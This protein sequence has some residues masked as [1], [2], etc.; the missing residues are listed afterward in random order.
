MALQPLVV[1]IEVIPEPHKISGWVRDWADVLK[2]HHKKPESRDANQFLI[3]TLSEKLGISLSRITIIKGAEN[4]FKE[5]KIGKDIT[6]EELC[7]ILEAKR[8]QE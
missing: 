2:V 4:R 7:V 8:P 6:L 1:N 3:K 5:V